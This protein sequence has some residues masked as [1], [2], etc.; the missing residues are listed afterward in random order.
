MTQ[1]HTPPTP[2]QIVFNFS[3]HVESSNNSMQSSAYRSSA[4]Y[5]Y[6]TLVDIRLQLGGC[7]NTNVCDYETRVLAACVLRES[8]LQQFRRS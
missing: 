2:V 4:A 8:C 7:D 1:Q 3:N 5:A 6:R